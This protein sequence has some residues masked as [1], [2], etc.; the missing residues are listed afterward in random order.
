MTPSS[1][2]EEEPKTTKKILFTRNKKEKDYMSN[3]VLGE[4]KRKALPE[5]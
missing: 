2:I 1:N 3:L 4:K 5:E